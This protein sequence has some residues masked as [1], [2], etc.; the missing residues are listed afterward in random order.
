DSRP[1]AEDVDVQ[2]RVRAQ[3]VR[4]VDGDAGCLPGSVETTH[5]G[6]VVAQHLTL[7]IGRDTTHE[8][9]TCGVHRYR[10]LHRVDPQVRSRELGDVG[11]FG[12]QHLGGKVRH[13]EHDVVLVGSAPTAGQ[14]LLHDRAGHDVAW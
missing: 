3:P 8:V 5:H 7:D 11:Q 1:A 4:P 2:Q 13:V 10:F 9:V 6:V 14:N 12:L